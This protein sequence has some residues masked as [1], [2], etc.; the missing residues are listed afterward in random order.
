MKNILDG[1]RAGFKKLQLINNIDKD[2]ITKTQSLEYRWS[3]ISEGGMT[4]L[5]QKAQLEHIPFQEAKTRG[6]SMQIYFQ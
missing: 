3:L 1:I 6:N 4:T 5:G 2:A